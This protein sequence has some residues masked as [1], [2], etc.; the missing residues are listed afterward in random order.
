[1]FGY[2]FIQISISAVKDISQR[3]AYDI[4]CLIRRSLCRT[5]IK[6]AVMYL[7]L[8]ELQNYLVYSNIFS[9][10]VTWFSFI[11]YMSECTVGI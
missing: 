11:F 2:L 10:R 5:R 6:R 9:F 1:M 8:V 3:V 7:T 4:H